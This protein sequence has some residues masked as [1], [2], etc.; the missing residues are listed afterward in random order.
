[1]KKK[2]VLTIALEMVYVKIKNVFVN[3]LSS[4]RTA[5]FKNALINAPNTAHAIVKLE[6]VLAI[7]DFTEKTVQIKNALMIAQQEVNATVKLENANVKK[8]SQGNF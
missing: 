6:N 2:S 1:M 5:H 3:L 7:K 4:E 8:L